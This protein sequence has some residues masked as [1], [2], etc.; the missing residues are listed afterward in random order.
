MMCEGLTYGD[1]TQ[2]MPMI[3]VIDAG[4]DLWPRPVSVKRMAGYTTSVISVPFAVVVV[5]LSMVSLPDTT[6]CRFTAWTVA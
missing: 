3:K 4:A 6:T 5:G 2:H 1:G